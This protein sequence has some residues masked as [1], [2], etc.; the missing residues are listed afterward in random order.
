M[1]AFESRKPAVKVD[2]F[3]TTPDSLSSLWN[4]LCNRLYLTHEAV[5]NGVRRNIALSLVFILKPAKTTIA[6]QVCLFIEKST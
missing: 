6:P 2:L 1:M 4:L 3:N 5:Q